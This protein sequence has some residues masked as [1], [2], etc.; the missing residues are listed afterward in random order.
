MR[1]SFHPSASIILLF[2]LG[3]G[4]C[5]PEPIEVGHHAIKPDSNGVRQESLF[6]FNRVRMGTRV[7]MLIHADEVHQ[8]ETA[9][10]AAFDRITAL[11]A[12][13]SDYNPASE[14][15]QFEPTIAGDAVKASPELI[16]ILIR[17]NQLSSMTGGAFDVTCGPLTRLWRTAFMKGS[18]P[19]F[20]QIEEA[21]GRVGWAFVS[22]DQ[23]NDELTFEW[24]GMALDFGAI[25]KGLAADAA[26][27]ALVQHGCPRSL[28][29]VG[30]DLAV[31]LPPPGAV[32]WS[33]GIALDAGDAQ[34][35]IVLS[36]C[37]VATSGNAEQHLEHDGVR[38]SHILDPRTG[39]ALTHSYAVTIQASDAATAD[40]IASAMSVLGPGMGARLVETWPSVH[41]IAGRT[42]E[43]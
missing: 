5:S 7:R 23:A 40:A 34:E 19:S 11:E 41:I 21:A 28:V 12:I 24:S 2:L 31:G 22:V 8:A 36:Q 32:G 30:G 27:S 20:A 29:D 16:R 42:R 17:A 6:E 13:L 33:V 1:P 26:L 37:G 15:R 10:S 4:G 25:G 38:Y 14:V 3:T 39:S 18:P 35:Q 9:A 43:Q